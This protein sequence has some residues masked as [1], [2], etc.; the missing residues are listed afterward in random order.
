MTDRRRLLVLASTYPRWAGDP[1]PAFVHELARRLVGSFDVTVLCPHAEGAAVR[2]VMDGVNIVR[3]RYAPARIEVLINGGGIMANL[4]RSRWR[5]LLLPGF[6]VSQLLATWRITR[7]FRPNVIHAHWIVPQGLVARLASIGLRRAAPLLLTSHGVDLFSLRGKF[8]MWLKRRVVRAATAM[9]VVSSAMIPE[10][11]HLGADAASC[12]VLPMGTDMTTRFTP[13]PVEREPTRLLFVGRLVE[14]KGLAHLLDAMPGIIH[15]HPSAVLD[16]VG[17]GPL[18]LVLKERVKAL[19]LDGKVR[20]LGA[21]PN[22]ELPEIYSRAGLLVAPFVVAASG[23]QEGLGLVVVEAV[24]CGCPVVI[25]EVPATREFGLDTLS[26]V[27]P[28]QITDAVTTLLD[29]SSADRRALADRQRG[30]VA[31]RFEWARVAAR[32]EYLL[33]KLVV[34]S[35]RFGEGG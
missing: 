8:S 27:T 21:V 12:E 11:L 32:Y 19:K 1:E 17:F 10:A 4:R 7:S 18:L 26:P 25:G 34:D 35:D 13:Q 20:F 29:N 3:Y 6:L 14:K 33:A 24:A 9:T 22:H 5:W 2:E 23:D 16:V 30:I 31:D 15:R 28:A